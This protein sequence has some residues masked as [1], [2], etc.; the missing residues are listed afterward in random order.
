MSGLIQFGG[1]M[2]EIDD[3]IL[4]GVRKMIERKEEELANLKEFWFGPE[5]IGSGKKE[6][7]D[8]N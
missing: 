5:D 1:G 4:K 2:A 7:N 8:K 6:K 3:L